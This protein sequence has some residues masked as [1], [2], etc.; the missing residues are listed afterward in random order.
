MQKIVVA[1]GSV[2]QPKLE[3][4]AAALDAS[5]SC[6]DPQPEF[7]VIGIEAPSGVR[8]TPLSRAET[9]QGAR[10]RAEALRDMARSQGAAWHYVVGLEGG[11]DMLQLNGSR[12]VF[13]ENW[14]YVM[15]PSGA[16]SYGQSGAV[17][18]PDALARQVIDHR[19][20][21]AQA[22]DQFA[23]SHGIRDREGAW[24]ILT[25]GRITRREAFRIAVI[26]AFAPHFNRRFYQA[27]G[28]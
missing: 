1:V 19:V 13:L 14:A 28:V 16:S 8:H 15:D 20:E 25:S 4:V 12:L 6:F 21:L 2:R 3:A 5:K 11:L 18:L 22:I 26:N 23:G 10:Q 24:G 27:S 7:E 9:M 17:L